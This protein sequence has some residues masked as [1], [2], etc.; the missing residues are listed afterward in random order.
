[1]KEPH[2]ESLVYR[3]ES[4]KDI[5]YDDPP[6]VEVDIDK[7][8]GCLENGILTCRM[9]THYAS[10]SDA[11][12]EIE[13]YLRAWEV[14]ANLKQGKG[15]I[16]FVYQDAN[17]IDLAP[18]KTGRGVVEIGG[19][20][21]GTGTM[22][23]SVQIIRKRYPP[24]PKNFIVSPDVETLW[25][26]Y[27]GYLDGKEHLQAMAFFC[28]NTVEGI[29]GRQEK[30]GNKRRQAAAH[31]IKIDFEV[32]NTLGELTSTRGDKTNARKHLAQFLPLTGTEHAWIES[33]IKGLI[34]RVGEYSGCCDNNTLTQIT[35]A[36]FPRPE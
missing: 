31:T 25:G 28:L 9:K 13:S 26:R 7:W 14:N 11:R 30:K 21:T 24:P 5:I 23:A 18:P 35:M 19:V 4:A 16:K 17:V 1:M 8:E 20:I 36:D 6:P 29:C 2:V 33:V 15:T 3:A 27:E 10:I 34:Y 12:K 32:L 22:A